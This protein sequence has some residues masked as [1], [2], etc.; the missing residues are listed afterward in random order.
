MSMGGAQNPVTMCCASELYWSP[1]LRSPRPA[2]YEMINCPSKT[3]AYTEQHLLCVVGARGG[4]VGCITFCVHWKCTKCDIAAPAK[5][6]P[7]QGY[8]YKVTASAG[9]PRPVHQV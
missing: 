2:A 4:G 8:A 9:G 5:G 7:E 3:W 6:G 1:S